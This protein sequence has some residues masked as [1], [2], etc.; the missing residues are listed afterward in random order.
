MCFFLLFSAIYILI[1]AANTNEFEVRAKL[2][3]ALNV[4]DDK[5]TLPEIINK[6]STEVNVDSHKDWD[7]I[8]RFVIVSSNLMTEIEAV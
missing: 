3:E 7:Q 2:K 1:F 4:Y 6:S 8:Q 5:N